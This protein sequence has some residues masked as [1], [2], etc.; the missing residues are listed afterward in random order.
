MKEIE[1]ELNRVVYIEM[2]YIGHFEEEGKVNLVLKK[3][4]EAKFDTNTSE[5]ETINDN[6]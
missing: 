6:F 4:T 2:V 1:G 3:M 5:L